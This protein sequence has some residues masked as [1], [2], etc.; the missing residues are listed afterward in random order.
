MIWI[1]IMKPR[2]SANAGTPHD[3]DNLGRN[4]LQM[5]FKVIK[6]GSN[7]K[8]AY[9]FLLV[10]CRHF[11]HIAHRLREIWCET[12]KMT[13]KYRQG[14]RH[15]YHL[16]AD[17][18]FLIS[19]FRFCGRILYNFRDINN[20]N[21]NTLIYIAPA[22]RMTSEAQYWTWEDEMAFKYHS[23]SSKVAPIES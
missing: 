4:N 6:S 18:W 2:T 16:K 8:L 13:L 11:C 22:C 20:N 15:S 9:D 12:V 3:D 17:V 10:L 7:R 5:Y 23:R 1:I 21:N 19:N 14:H